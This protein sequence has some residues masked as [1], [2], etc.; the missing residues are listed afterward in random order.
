M[1][2]NP[3]DAMVQAAF[4]ISGFPKNR[5]HRH[6][7]RARLGAHEHVRGAG[8]WTSRSKTCIP[9]C[10]AATA[11]TWC[12]CRATP[13]SPAFPSPTCCPRRRI[14]AIVDA[15]AQGRRG[16]RQSAEDRLGLLRAF[17]RRRGNGRSDPQG[18]E[19]NSSLRRLSRRRIR[20][21]RPLRRRAG[22]ARRARRGTD[23]RN[24]ADRRKKTPRCKNRPLRCANWSPS[25]ASR[26][27]VAKWDGR[28]AW[29]K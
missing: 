11:T 26:R 13:P 21:Q 2:T 10:S 18:Q 15:H 6:G 9:S 28:L 16:N 1:V 5:V 7:R 27:I 8:T 17:G 20:N 23:H 29:R 3:L 12:R 25:S 19:E 24:Q 14:D 4:K 22:E